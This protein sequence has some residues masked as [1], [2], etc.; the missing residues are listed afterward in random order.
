MERDPESGNNKGRMHCP[1]FVISITRWLL[2]F[3]QI[4][5]FSQQG[6]GC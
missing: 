2:L 3:Q 5:D 6:F 1:A 4:A